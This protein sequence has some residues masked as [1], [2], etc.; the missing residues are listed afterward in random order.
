[1]AKLRC[2]KI[3]PLPL[4]YLVPPLVDVLTFP[5]DQ[6]NLLIGKNIHGTNILMKYQTELKKESARLE[7][8]LAEKTLQIAQLQNQINKYYFH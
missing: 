8:E 6:L 3:F 5:L 7:R 4:S 2:V 1:M